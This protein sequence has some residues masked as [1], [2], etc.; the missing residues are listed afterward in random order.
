M[1]EAPEVTTL[2]SALYGRPAR[3]RAL[4]VW[5]G[6]LA[7]WRRG[8]VKRLVGEFGSVSKV[9]DREPA[10]L[11][12]FIRATGPPA[13]GPG[14]GASDD[15]KRFAV[16]LA[17]GPDGVPKPSATHGGWAVAWC[18]PLYPPAVR[19]LADPPLCLFVRADCPAAEASRRL[20]ELCGRPAVAIVG[21]RVP[22]PYGDEMAV[23][24]GR[25]LTT[26]GILVVSGMALGIDAAAQ[27]AA[28]EAAPAAGTLATVGVLGCGVD[29]VYPRQHA[30]LFGAVARRGLLISEFTAGVP[31]RPWRFPARNRVMAAL[32]LGVVVV[33][34][35]SRSGARLTADFAL[36]LGREV[37]AVPGE[38][39]KKLS[40]AP[41]R[42][43]RDGAKLCESAADVLDGISRVR[44]PDVES[45]AGDLDAATVAQVLLGSAGGGV[46]RVSAVLEALQAGSMTSEQVAARCSLAVG[47]ACALLTELEI[48]G[49]AE[50]VPGGAFRLRRH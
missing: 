15:E 43:L 22:S 23:A 30:A 28:L 40:A 49:L 37:L 12:D 21:T 29:V 34:G 19:Q 17:A 38:A 8:L 45:L 41:H 25:D 3:R 11:A 33:E 44:L 32:G 4:C 42:L 18:D 50:Q 6:T 20:R 2:R 31:A 24:L 48:D 36:D 16:A 35:A 47:E 1:P 26:Q 39:G 10:Q 9:L 27:R 5:L 7:S 13:E 46:T 14:D